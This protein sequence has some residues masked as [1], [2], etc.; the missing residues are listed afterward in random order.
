MADALVI[1]DGSG[2]LPQKATFSSPTDGDVMF[3]I[4]GTAWTQSAPTMT[5]ITVT[6]DGNPIGSST[7]FAN[8]NASHQA[9]RTTFIPFS[10]MTVDTHAITIQAANGNTATDFNDTFQVVMFY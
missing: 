9:M 5:G 4:S 10:G 2:P 3:A 8:E 7:C 6:L 1:F